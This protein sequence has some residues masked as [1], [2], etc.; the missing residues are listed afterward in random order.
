MGKSFFKIVWHS[1]SGNHGKQRFITLVRLGSHC[2]LL[3]DH[4]YT[5]VVVRLE[6]W[7]PPPHLQNIFW[8]LW[9]HFPGLKQWVKIKLFKY[10]NQDAYIVE[11]LRKGKLLILNSSLVDTFSFFLPPS[12]SFP[13]FRACP[14]AL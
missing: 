10:L 8:C 4:A 11:N 1:K 6:T 13:W 9:I 3:A 7:F 14:Y 2:G 5:G 12:L